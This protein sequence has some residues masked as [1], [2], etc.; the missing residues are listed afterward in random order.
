MYSVSKGGHTALMWAVLNG[1]KEIAKNLLKAEANVDLQN[2]VG[3]V[4]SGVPSK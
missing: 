1:Y 2:K 3:N 4:C